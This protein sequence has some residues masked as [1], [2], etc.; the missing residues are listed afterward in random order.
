MIIRLFLITEPFSVANF[1]NIRNCTENQHIKNCF[2]GNISSLRSVIIYSCLADSQDL[3][4][5]QCIIVHPPSWILTA[6][7]KNVN[8]HIKVKFLEKTEWN[9]QYFWAILFN[10]NLLHQKTLEVSISK[11]SF[12]EK[13]DLKWAYPGPSHYWMDYQ[14]TNFMLRQRKKVFQTV[15]LL[16]RWGT[17]G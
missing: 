4:G 8:N 11:A 17:R 6:K 1:T 12:K 3:V 7:T 9:S 2:I 14:T 15:H 16:Q 10:I 5:A 13:F